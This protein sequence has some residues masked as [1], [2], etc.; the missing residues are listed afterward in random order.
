MCRRTGVTLQELLQTLTPLAS[1]L[2]VLVLKSNK[3]RGTIMA[4]F[5]PFTK[6]KELNM[7]NMNLE[8]RAVEESS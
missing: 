3:L 7:S 5:A 4:D 2:E 1:S 8:G 6:L